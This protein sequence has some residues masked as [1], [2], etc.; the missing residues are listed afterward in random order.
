MHAGFVIKWDF[1]PKQRFTSI[2]KKLPPNSEWCWNVQMTD[3]LQKNE[4]D[5]HNLQVI[6]I[7]LNTKGICT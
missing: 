1:S 7:P 6:S 5:N 4:R 2:W 3:I